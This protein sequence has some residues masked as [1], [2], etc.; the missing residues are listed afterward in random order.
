MAYNVLE[1]IASIKSAYSIG[2]FTS[3][4]LLLEGK[5]YE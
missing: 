3:L 2:T 4:C 5:D 1:E